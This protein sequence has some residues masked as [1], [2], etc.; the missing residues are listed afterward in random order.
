MYIIYIG[1][2][3]LTYLRKKEDHIPSI[4][5]FRFFFVCVVIDILII[6]QIPVQGKSNTYIGI[7]YFFTKHV[8]LRWSTENV[9]QGGKMVYPSGMR[10]LSKHNVTGS[11]LDTA[12]NV[13]TLNLT[14]ITQSFTN[15]F[16]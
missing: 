15:L 6:C 11:H 12:E 13:P 14:T 9:W 1:K 4:Q 3:Y 7:D 2:D 10:Y 16:N 5:S 8:S